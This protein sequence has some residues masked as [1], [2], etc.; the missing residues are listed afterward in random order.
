MFYR[1]FILALLLITSSA[2]AVDHSFTWDHNPPSDEVVNYRIY[3]KTDLQEYDEI[4]NIDTGYTNEFTI[5]NMSEDHRC[6][7]VTAIDGYDRESDHSN[8]VCTAE[9]LR[10]KIR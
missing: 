5:H 2:W 3:W 7:V 6:F 8:E 4:R 10:W 9:T 1:S